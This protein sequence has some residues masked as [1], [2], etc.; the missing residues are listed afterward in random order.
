MN[1]KAKGNRNEYRTMRLLE[2]LGYTCFRMAGSFGLFDVIDISAID[3]LLVHV[4]SNRF[5]RKVE[6]E[7]ISKL[8]TPVDCGK[9]IYVWQDRES[10]PL[11][12][13]L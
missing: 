6:I 4:K 8:E 2:S 7:A 5:R 3:V 1:R 10:V 12:T 9:V 11:V 13:G